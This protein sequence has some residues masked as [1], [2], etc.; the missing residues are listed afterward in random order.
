MQG[1]IRGVSGHLWRYAF[2]ARPLPR[3]VDA[4]ANGVAVHT[5]LGAE[6]FG[7]KRQPP[8][9]PRWKSELV[10][11]GLVLVGDYLSGR[12]AADA[13]ESGWAGGEVLCTEGLLN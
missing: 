11:P 6:I 2:A 13:Y 9:V 10:R 8:L 12:L 4:D 7:H 5:M 1:T 3:K